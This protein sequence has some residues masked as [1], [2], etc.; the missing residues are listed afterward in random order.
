MINTKN[1]KTLMIVFC[2]AFIVLGMMS[3]ANADWG[4]LEVPFTISGPLIMLLIG[5]GIV[6]VGLVSRFR[7]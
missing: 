3:S 5:L 6:G 7:K 2:T 1:I 4:R